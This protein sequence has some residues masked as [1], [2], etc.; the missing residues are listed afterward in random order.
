MVSLIS[1]SVLDPL[2]NLRSGDKS[3]GDHFHKYS[4]F[5]NYIL[6]KEK[7]IIEW[8]LNKSDK[9]VTGA[10]KILKIPRTTLRSKMEKLSMRSFEE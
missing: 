9:N 3:K 8:A 1:R 5:D 4:G 10:A 2:I 7:E 6:S